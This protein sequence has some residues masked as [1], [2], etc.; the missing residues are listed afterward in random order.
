ME[1]GTARFERHRHE[2][3]FGR[4]NPYLPMLYRF[5][6]HEIHQLLAVGDIARGE[7]NGHE[8]GDLVLLDARHELAGNPERSDAR[9][10]LLKLAHERIDA[11]LERLRREREVPHLE[12]EIPSP[13]VEPAEPLTPL[14][15]E[16]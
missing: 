10:R 6:G 11:E 13:T 4:V 15:R 14:D 9:A 5:V 1:S 8:I 3:W 2:A 12:E 16:F 7:L